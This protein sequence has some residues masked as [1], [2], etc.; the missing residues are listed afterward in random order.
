MTLWLL[1][2]IVCSDIFA[3]W[4]DLHIAGH[5]NDAEEMNITYLQIVN[6]HLWSKSSIF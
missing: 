2:V 5:Y 3:I 4:I 6:I 1:Y